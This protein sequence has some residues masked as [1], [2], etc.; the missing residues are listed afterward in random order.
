MRENPTWETM[1]PV[2]DGLR[3][4]HAS[5]GPHASFVYHHLLLCAR[6]TGEHKGKVFMTMGDLAEELAISKS[7]VHRACAKLKGEYIEYEPSKNQNS[8]TVFTILKHK[9]MAD[10][11]KLK[12]NAV[13]PE[14]QRRNSGG[15]AE[16]QRWNSGGTA[17]EQRG[18]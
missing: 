10:F 6:K 18:S 11:M 12:K 14:G 7:T 2:S 5:M 15:T 4:H 17:A 3:A 16:E 9:T 1:T 13:S 8:V